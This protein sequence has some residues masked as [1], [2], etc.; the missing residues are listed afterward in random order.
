MSGRPVADEPVPDN[1]A[2]EWMRDGYTISD[3]ASRLD[4]DVIHGFLVDAYWCQGIPRDVLERAIAG[5]LNFGIYAPG[6]GQVG[7]ARCVTDRATFCWIGDVF[8]LADQR[9][10]R[11]A[12]WLMETIVAH[13]ELQ[14]LR[15][16]FLGTRDAHDL[17]RKTGF[18]ELGEPGGR[19]MLRPSEA[20]YGR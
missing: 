6:G 11:L 4:V 5:S 2:V 19:Y 8:V 20:N 16:W 9:G 12:V 18:S 3:D 17:Y 7:F 10:R 14:G 15:R 13:P 1:G